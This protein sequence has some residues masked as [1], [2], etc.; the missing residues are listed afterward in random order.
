[1]NRPVATGEVRLTLS[2]GSVKRSFENSGN[3]CGLSGDTEHR[4]AQAGGQ[5]SISLEQAPIPTVAP[6]FS[7]MARIAVRLA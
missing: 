5:R 6:I 3:F 2:T 4:N 1:M 7:S